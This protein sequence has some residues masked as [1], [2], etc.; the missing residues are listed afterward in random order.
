MKQLRYTILFLAFF[1]CHC[2][3]GSAMDGVAVSGLI[4]DEKQDPLPGMSVKLYKFADNIALQSTISDIK[5]SYILKNLP[6]GKYKIEVSGI[7]FK[8]GRLSFTINEPDENITLPDIILQEDVTSLQEVVVTSQKQLLEVS[9]GKLVYNVDQKLA[10]SGNS[11]FE[12]LQRTPS[13]SVNQD[14]NL[15]LKGN[16]N[17]NIMIDGKMTYLSPRQL[18]DLLKST[19]AENLS[20][21]EIISAPSSQYDAAGNAGIINIITKKNRQQGYALNITAGAGTGRYAQTA[22]SIIGNIN[23]KAFNLFGSYSY[24]YKHSFLDRSSYRVIARNAGSTIYDRASF[25]PS[26]GNNHSYKAGMDIYLN[27]KHEVG[28]VYNGFY[29]L[30]RRNA[31]GPTNISG[32][33]SAGVVQNK[34]ITREPSFNHAANVNYRFQIDTTGKQVSFDGDYSFYDNN[35]SGSLANQLFNTQG[36]SIGTRQELAFQQ[37]GRI[38]IRSIKTDLVLPFKNIKLESG[39]KYSSVTTNNNFR[40]DSLINNNFVFSTV[41]SNQF[42]YE[43]QITAAYAT[44]GK[45]FGK[46]N[47]DAGL[48][49]EITRSDANAVTLDSVTQRNYT[50]LFPFLSISRELNKAHQLSLSLSRRINRPQYSNLNPSRYFFDKFSYYE[51]NPLLQPENSWN[52]ASTYTFKNKYIATLTYSRTSRPIA[53]FALE[54]IQTGELVV[55]SVNF[56]K[57]SDYDLLLIVPLTITNF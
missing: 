41:L 52:L 7:G 36:T 29:N 40:Y 26:V 47:L 33:P 10:V 11:A 1:L 22:E 51:G 18:S 20:K 37:P 21:I 4:K 43:E 30:W 46:L 56:S 15:L 28:F 39:L 32:G 17:V 57:R 50:N 31:G 42:V 6:A 49:I 38:N 53:D 3:K 12:L 14:D 45:Q 34:N 13:V 35:S 5:G 24:N 16:G 55:T 9:K 27:P 23:T 54:N 44:A 25:D 8:A 48:R 2:K 19:P